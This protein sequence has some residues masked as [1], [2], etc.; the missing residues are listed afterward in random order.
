[1]EDETNFFRI[2]LNWSRRRLLDHDDEIKALLT[3]LVLY[4]RTFGTSTNYNTHV[5][6]RLRC[7]VLRLVRVSGRV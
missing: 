6:P 4:C 7:L 3:A 2:L 1:M 5:I